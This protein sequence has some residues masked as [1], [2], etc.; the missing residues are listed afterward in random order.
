MCDD[1]TLP[2]CEKDENKDIFVNITVVLGIIIY[3][4]KEILYKLRKRGF[5]L[6]VKKISR[7]YVTF[8]VCMKA[9]Y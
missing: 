8:S 9:K 4:P 3:F 6:K 1:R 7:N 2:M 5:A